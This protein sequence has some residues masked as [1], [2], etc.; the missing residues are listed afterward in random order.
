[1]KKT[2]I[3]VCIT[4]I[5]NFLAFKVSPTTSDHVRELSTRDYQSASWR[6]LQLQSG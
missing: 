1:L 4:K 3:H 5:Q 2:A 6:I